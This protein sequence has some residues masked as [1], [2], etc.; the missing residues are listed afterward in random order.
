MI[1]D[2]NAVARGARYAQDSG[3]GAQGGHLGYSGR[4]K[5]FFS[6]IFIMPGSLKGFWH[7][8]CVFPARLVREYLD[9]T[10]A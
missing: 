2:G 7:V 1:L 6:P 3:E 9:E 8:F 10:H 4:R 5:V